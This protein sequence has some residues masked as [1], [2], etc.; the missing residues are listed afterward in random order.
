MGGKVIFVKLQPFDPV[1][2]KDCKPQLTKFNLSIK[3]NLEKYESF[4]IICLFSFKSAQDR[5]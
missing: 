1:L 4:V 2:R 5:K 3:I